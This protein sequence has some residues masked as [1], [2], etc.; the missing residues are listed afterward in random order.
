[1]PKQDTP[2]TDGL[3]V[4]IVRKLGGV[5]HIDDVHKALLRRRSLRAR[6]IEYYPIP[7]KLRTRLSWVLSQSG[8]FKSEGRRGSGRYAMREGPHPWRGG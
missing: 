7:Q 2:V 5:V 1:M 3:V 6:I 8:F 4:E